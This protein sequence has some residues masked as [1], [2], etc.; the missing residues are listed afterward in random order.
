[1]I[2]F[3]LYH[4]SI[5]RLNF[6]PYRVIYIT[7]FPH[8]EGPVSHTNIRISKIESKSQPVD[9]YSYIRSKTGL[10]VGTGHYYYEKIRILIVKQE[11]GTITQKELSDLGK[12]ITESKEY[13]SKFYEF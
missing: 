5:S 11:S 3:V 12:L 9:Q 7:R 10:D 4:G 6:L 8:T 1:M 13:Y 2:Q